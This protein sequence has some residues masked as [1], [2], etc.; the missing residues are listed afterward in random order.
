MSVTAQMATA[1]AATA[2][3]NGEGAMDLD[4]VMAGLSLNK[5]NL[6]YDSILRLQQLL[7]EGMKLHD[8]NQAKQM[9]ELLEKMKITEKPAF[10]FT[11]PVPPQQT[12]PSTATGR[13]VT[14]AKWSPSPLDAQTEKEVERTLFGESPTR[15]PSF[16]VGTPPSE[17]SAKDKRH[18][19]VSARPSKSK[20]KATVP[21]KPFQV[22][23]HDKPR[24]AR[25]L[26][27][28][29]VQHMDTEEL[30][31]GSFTVGAPPA[32]KKPPGRPPGRPKSR[33]SVASPKPGAAPF[34][35][36]A[37]KPVEPP[38]TAP[39][40]EDAP[41]AS[42]ALGPSSAEKK[43]TQR[44]A[45]RADQK[46]LDA[47]DEAGRCYERGD[48]A[49]AVTHYTTCLDA[50]PSGWS[51]AAKA[52]GNRGAARTMLGKHDDALGDCDRAVE[53]EPGLAKVHNR[54]ARLRL[55]LGRSDEARR[56]F[57]RARGASTQAIESCRAAMKPPPKDAL[58]C[59]A[60]A[61]AG[62]VDVH[63]YEDALRRAKIALD[64]A[65]GHTSQEGDEENKNS[66]QQAAKRRSSAQRDVEVDRALRAAEDALLRAP[67]AAAARRAKARAL[68]AGDRWRECAAFCD[69]TAA[70]VA[71][72]V[73]GDAPERAA[74]VARALASLDASSLDVDDVSLPELWV[75]ALR[76]NEAPDEA[77]DAVRSRADAALKAVVNTATENAPRGARIRCEEALNRASKA[78]RA[79]TRADDAYARGHYRAAAAM[80]RDA[81]RLDAFSE[82]AGLRAAVHCNVAACALV[83][84]RCG[85]AVDAC[86]KALRLRPDY[87]RARLRRARARA[88]AGDLRDAV[89]DF[90]RYL[91]GARTGR[92]DKDLADAER[93][94]AQAK[95][96]IETQKAERRRADA[97][98][99][100]PSAAAP[101]P[102]PPRRASSRY[103]PPPPP[104]R[105]SPFGGAGRAKPPPSSST[106]VARAASYHDVLGV[107]RDA[108][109]V[110][111]KKAYAKLA[112][113]FHPDRCTSPGATA[114]MAK[115][116]EAYEQAMIQSKARYR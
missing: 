27:F 60:T 101:P 77:C 95:A 34:V 111:I 21:I 22:G 14:G 93:E 58:A 92:G 100:R 73:A 89:G 61:D 20:A 85:E 50:A 115:I 38:V 70:A 91:R 49:Q 103:A 72:P 105:R 114:A 3:T 15:P 10:Q 84:E 12:A 19:R 26:D 104:P 71:A 11:S 66:A 56:S 44:R 13:P 23:A 59:L 6:S 42:F 31:V 54:S 5:D 113:R 94:R 96:A 67:L 16:S 35:F 87:L 1:A 97:R 48:Y 30:P 8:P 17:P 81:L 86:T 36:Q 74:H 102:P 88:R 107:A 39:M 7:A 25:V 110:V 83:L 9:G 69:A 79:K 57:E 52:L 90:D 108:K 98:R 46:A 29:H 99:K 109:P 55:A 4:A 32:P 78:R 68:K 75:W 106:G 47:Y 80:Y 65:R 112:L 116:N 51:L 40:E 64:A 76:R 28:E 43:K 82:V 24:A 45:P 41:V 2:T 63:R 18:K 62:L 37:T 33:H 53:L